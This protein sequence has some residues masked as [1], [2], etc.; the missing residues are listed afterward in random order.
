MLKDIKDAK[1]ISCYDALERRYICEE[2]GWQKWKDMDDDTSYELFCLCRDFVA[3]TAR[4][5]RRIR[6]QNKGMNYIEHCGILRRLTYNFK[7]GE[8]EYIA[9]QDYN[10]EM[11]TLREIFD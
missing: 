4:G 11:K 9:G 1:Q 2:D 8:V 10:E 5:N 6:I 3:K 7:L